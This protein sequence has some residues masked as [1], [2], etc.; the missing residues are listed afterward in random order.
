MHFNFRD[1]ESGILFLSLNRTPMAAYHVTPI[2]LFLEEGNSLHFVINSASRVIVTLYSLTFNFTSLW[3][4]INSLCAFLLFITFQRKQNLSLWKHYCPYLQ[5][6]LFSCI[7]RHSSLPWHSIRN[8]EGWIIRY[9]DLK[10]GQFCTKSASIL[11]C[12]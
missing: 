8:K 11:I 6:F 1:R 12:K 7:W 2:R 10:N 9:G 3:Y 4:T 5:Y